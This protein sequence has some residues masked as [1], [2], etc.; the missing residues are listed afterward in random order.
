L[1]IVGPVVAVVCAPLVVIVW[2]LVEHTAPGKALWTAVVKLTDVVVP[3][4]L[5][6][7]TVLVTPDVLQVVF[8]AIASISLGGILG[9]LIFGAYWSLMSTFAARHT[10]HAFSALGLKNYKHF[11]RMRFEKDQVTIYPIAIDKV[12]GRRGWRALEHGE[13][14]PSHSPQIVPK[15][16]LRP[17]L[18]EPPIIIRAGDVKA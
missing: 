12:P 2:L 13:T 8:F 18:I 11:L 17:H 9:A 15:K 4:A 16:G 1:L 5:S 14:R 6:P 7:L 10:D 3:F